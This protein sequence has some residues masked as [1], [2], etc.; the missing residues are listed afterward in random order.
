MPDYN[1]LMKRLWLTDFITEIDQTLIYKE[2]FTDDWRIQGASEAFLHNLKNCRRLKERLEK[3]HA[4]LDG[5]EE[6]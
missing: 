4:E 3:I 1:A 2:M 5:E 6:D